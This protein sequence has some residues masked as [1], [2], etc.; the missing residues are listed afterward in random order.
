MNRYVPANATGLTQGVPAGPR[1]EVAHF[2]QLT[3]RV[4]AET[5]QEDNS[6]ITIV[7]ASTVGR[8]SL[9]SY[10]DS[11]TRNE[12]QVPREEW[13][14]GV[15]IDDHDLAVH[16]A[17]LPEIHPETADIIASYAEIGKEE[18]DEGKK[19]I[20]EDKGN[21]LDR[22]LSGR[23]AFFQLRALA[24]KVFLRAN[25]HAPSFDCLWEYSNRIVAQQCSHE[26]RAKK[27]IEASRT[28][29]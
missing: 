12:Y 17:R 26:I 20:A 19:D 29:T 3:R 15:H 4:L 25:P 7:I 8:T 16:F 13:Y 23:P 11:L 24:N 1:P 18:L 28:L 6:G 9:A 27:I 21:M 10:F 14:D 5:D 2:N 22:Y